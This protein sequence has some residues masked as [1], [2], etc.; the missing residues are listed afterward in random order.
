[1]KKELRELLD[2]WEKEKG[3]D[4]SFLIESLEKGLAAVYRK[5]A[6]LPEGVSVRIDTETGDI[7]FYDEGGGEVSPPSFP[8]ERIAAQTAKQVLIQKLREAEKNA[9]FEDFKKLEGEIISGRV[10]RFEDGHIILA[11]GRTEALLPQH[12]KLPS[13]RHL[14][15]GDPLRVLLLE[16]RKP[17]RGLYQLIVSRVHANFVRKLLMNE[18]PELQEGLVEIKAIARFP[19]DL[20]KVAVASNNERIDPLG[21]CVGDKALRI[22]SISKDLGG[23]RIEII[24][25]SEDP[26]QLVLNALSPARAGEVILNEDRREAIVLVGDDQLYLAIGKRGQN[27]RLASKLTNWNIRVYRY[28]EYAEAEKPATTLIAGMDSST[29]EKLARL[30]FSSIRSLAD[31]TAEEIASVLSIDAEAA[32]ALIQSARNHLKKAEGSPDAT[33]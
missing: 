11:C 33:S 31:A 6:G 14:R 27:V 30:G 1:M 29:A 2:F 22:K 16:V 26:K 5:K 7:R 15:P 20:T 32:A 18:I 8:W 23:E 3:I 25:W 10:E 4:R 9:I 13:D 28:A 12:H 21:T 24:A 17:N 19:G